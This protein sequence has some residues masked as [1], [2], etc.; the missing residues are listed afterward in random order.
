MAAP[1]RIALPGKLQL[2]ML[3]GYEKP[4]APYVVRFRLFTRFRWTRKSLSGTYRTLSTGRLMGI[5]E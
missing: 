2:L 3:A 1:R 4:V 5:T